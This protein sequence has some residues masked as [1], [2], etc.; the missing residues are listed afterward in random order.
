M[1]D[2][3]WIKVYAWMVKTG[4]KAINEIP[5][6]YQEAVTNRLPY[7]NIVDLDKITELETKYQLL[8]ETTSE[9]NDNLG[10]F[11]DYVFT[12]LNV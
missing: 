10:G 11:I 2:E 12:Q 1:L 4:K 8:S 6:E 7:M 9:L 5:T 3:K